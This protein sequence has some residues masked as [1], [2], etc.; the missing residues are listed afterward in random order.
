MSGTKQSGKAGAKLAAMAG[1]AA[2][3][4]IGLASVETHY[5]VECHNA[6]GE[7]LWVEE[8]HNRVVTAGL[9]KLLDA[10]FKTGLTTPAWYVGLVGVSITDAAITS[11]AAALTSASN[12][13]AAG[14]AGR[15]IIVRGAGA[16][17][18]DLVT[19]IL[20]YSSAGAVTLAAN[21]GTTVTGARALWDARAADTM[22][23]HTPWP[24]VAAYSEAN[25]QTLTLGTISAGSVDNSASKAV[26]TINADNTYIGGAFIADNNTKSGTTGVLYG[27]AP[28]TSGGIRQLMTG[29][30]VSVQA[31]LSVAA[32]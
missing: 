16:S 31:T 23:S 29:D 14:D 25:R 22:S 15:A 7:L 21:A 26:F 10:T 12:P 11:G 19:T 3:A 5:R 32:V 6:A 1:V 28:F 18:A 8:C 9:N 24:E 4:F 2:A 30:T 17:G 13:F 27:M 20:S